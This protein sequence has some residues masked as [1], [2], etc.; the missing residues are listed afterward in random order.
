MRILMLKDYFYPEQCAGISLAQDLVKEFSENNHFVEVF[1]PI[2]CR[3]I[4]SDIRKK[5][6]NKKIESHGN[7]TIHRYWLPYEKSS[8]LSRA[9]RYFLQ[10]IRIENKQKG[11]FIIRHIHNSSK[12]SWKILRV[13]S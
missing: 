1:T 4:T 10:N 11:H 2:P 3:G 5:Y 7:A 8:V 9:L 12:T 6:R 13:G